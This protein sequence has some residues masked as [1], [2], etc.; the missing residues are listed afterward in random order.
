[1][2]QRSGIDLGEG[3][4]SLVQGRLLRRLRALNLSGFEQY[5]PLIEDIQSA[6]A[7]SFLN[8]L[9][10]N[11]TEF[12]REP[13]HFELLAK[14]ILPDLL[15]KHARTRKLRMWSAGCS[16][17]EEPYSLAIV[18]RECCPRDGWDCKIL[19]TDID[20]D[21]LAHASAGIYPLERAEKIGAARLRTH[22]L[23]GNG[24]QQ[25]FVRVKSELSSLVAFRR[26]NL[27]EPWPMHGP[28]DFI[29][30]RNVIIYFDPETRQGLVKR[31][32][33][34]LAPGGHLFLGHSESLT[35]NMI[36]FEPC[37]KTVYR[38]DGGG[39]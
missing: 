39:L 22:F 2:K 35:G 36:G 31:Y 26:L 24:A 4:R 33:E 5:L 28:F 6:E 21:V 15:K 25:G 27:M 9:T 32:R 8:A 37:A 18:L 20:S 17:G 34:L 30:C 10:T 38:R 13:H 7:E 3:K 1:V 16:T 12:F 23:R 14:T 29:F 19:A 11:V